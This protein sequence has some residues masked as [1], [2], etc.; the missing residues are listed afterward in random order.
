[1]STK[2][3]YGEFLDQALHKKFVAGLK[4]KGLQRQLLS[5]EKLA[6]AQALQKAK[7]F[8]AT[9]MNSK[10]LKYPEPMTVKKLAPASPCFHSGKSNHLP[11]ECRFWNATCH[12][13]H[14]TC[15]TCGL[16]GHISPVCK[17]KALISSRTKCSNQ[18]KQRT[19]TTAKT[20]WMA[21][22]TERASNPDKLRSDRSMFLV[23]DHHRISSH[24]YPTDRNP[25]NV[26]QLTHI[27]DYVSS[28][29]FAV[30]KFHPYLYG[31]KFTL[32]TDHKPLT[33]TLGPKNAVS[34]LAAARLQ[35]WALLLSAYLYDK[36]YKSSDKHTNADGFAYPYLS[37]I[38]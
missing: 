37:V 7:A 10:A 30:K 8:E 19:K 34:A 17:S 2:C 12:R 22:T 28:L 29:I 16:T 21:S 35:R 9:E 31:R 23:Q 18:G 13:C 36:Q 1:M 11:E 25:A 24:L 14:A 4:S 5:E 32:L 15:H 20:K 38:H 26:S 6:L 33:T 3:E 27:T